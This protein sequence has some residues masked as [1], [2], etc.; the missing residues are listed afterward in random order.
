MGRHIIARAAGLM[1]GLCL[2]YS[3]NAADLP[4]EHEVRRLIIAADSAIG[5]ERWNDASRHLTRLQNLQAE[6]PADYQFLRGRVMLQADQ[7]NE[8]Q[9]ALEAYVTQAGTEGKY[10]DQS[11]QLI[12]RIED[13]RQVSPEKTGNKP[14]AVIEPAERIDTEALKSLYLETSDRGAL[15][16]HL[17]SLLSLNAWQ[18]G[19]VIRSNPSEGVTY[20]V[21]IGTDASLQIKE[22]VREGEGGPTLRTQSLSVFGVNPV[23][24]H[25]CFEADNTCWLYDPRNRSRWL[26]LANRPEGSAETARVLSELIRNLQK[27][28]ASGN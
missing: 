21:T 2:S 8:A 13:Q 16:A 6:K 9:S 14:V 4:P 18:P 7:L 10:Y 22:A 5:E 24:S 1:L 27:G 15:I 19:P 25:A 12:T 26:R 3:L 28:G 11:L 23:V 20:Q 17:N